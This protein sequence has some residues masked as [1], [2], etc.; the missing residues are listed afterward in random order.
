MLVQVGVPEADAEVTLS[1]RQLFQL[2]PTRP[3]WYGDCIPTRDFPV[4]LDLYRQGRLDLDAFIT[5]TIAL[6]DV[7]EAF[8]KMEAGTVLRSVVV[9]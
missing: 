2:G 5:E 7:P 8:E 4:L 9:L 1:L 6:E 3:S